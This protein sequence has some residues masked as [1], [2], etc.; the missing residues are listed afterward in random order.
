MD[1]NVL[2][3]QAEERYRDGLARLPEESDPRQKQVT[4]VAGAWTG[5]SARLIGQCSVA[6]KVRV[7]RAALQRSWR[8]ERER[9]AG[10]SIRVSA[11]DVGLETIGLRLF[12]PIRT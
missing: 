12:T 10:E 2:A 11:R 6:D 7:V 1:W 3:E 9:G 4:R 5:G 8:L